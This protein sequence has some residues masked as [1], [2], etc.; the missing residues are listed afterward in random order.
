M[1]RRTNQKCT[2]SAT[3]WE[4]EGERGKQRGA[5]DDAHSSLG[6]LHLRHRNSVDG[7]GGEGG[8]GDGVVEESP[9]HGRREKEEN[10]GLKGRKARS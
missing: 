7:A 5:G 4:D 3:A 10:G 8:W 1:T 2:K 6:Y 9:F